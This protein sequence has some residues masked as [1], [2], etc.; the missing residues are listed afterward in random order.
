[1]EFLSSKRTG[2]TL[3]LCIHVLFRMQSYVRETILAT[4]AVIVKR[5]RVD[6]SPPDNTNAL[7]FNDIGQLIS[8]G[9]L[10]LVS[11]PC[12]LK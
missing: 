6:I 8:S 11:A 7:L 12:I 1:M 2:V 9:D 3:Y 5:A 4:V 10:S